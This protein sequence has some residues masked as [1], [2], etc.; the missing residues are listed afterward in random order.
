MNKR[1]QLEGLCNKCYELRLKPHW[2]SVYLA[3]RV[4]LSFIF[5]S[6]NHKLSI[7]QRVSL[8]FICQ[9]LLLSK[10][11]EFKEQGETGLKP[12]APP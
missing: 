5:W 12:K 9:N 1:L 10:H 11:H 2:L 4:E 6:G 8:K 7:F 3:K